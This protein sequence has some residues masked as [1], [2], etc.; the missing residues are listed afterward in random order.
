MNSFLVKDAKYETLMSLFRGDAFMKKAV[1]ILSFLSVSAC[2]NS[3]IANA[4]AEDLSAGGVSL[5]VARGE[6]VVKEYQ[7]PNGVVETCRI[8]EKLPGGDYSKKDMVQEEKLCSFDFYDSGKIALCAK[9][10][11]T[12]PATMVLK[13]NKSLNPKTNNSFTAQEYEASSYCGQKT[14]GP[15]VKT[16]AK[17]KTTMNQSD[18][19]GT[20]SQSSLLYYHFSRLLDTKINVPVSVY[21]E[22]DRQVMGERVAQRSGRKAKRGRIASGWKWMRKTADNPSS[23]KPTH[24]LITEDRDK[25]YGI[26]IRG[27]GARYGTI[28]NGTRPSWG[29]GDAKAFKNTPAFY[30]LRSAKPLREAIKE[31][32]AKAK[33]TRG[34]SQHVD[35]NISNLQMLFWMREL[36]ELTLLDYIFSQQDRVGNIDFDWYWYYVKDGEVKRTKESRDEYKKLSRA[37]M[38]QIPVPAE[39]SSYQ[40]TLVQRTN[41]NDNDAGGLVRY[42]NWA[43][44]S[45]ADWLSGQKHY[46]KK[47]F[48]N[49]MALNEDLQSGGPIKLWLETQLNLGASEVRQVVRNTQLAVQNILPRCE[50]LM[51]DLDDVDSFLT[52][53][54]RSEAVDC[55][56][57]R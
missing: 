34:M 1:I 42:A 54:F 44:E 37:K 22:M 5:E 38:G 39:L 36:T 15:G 35:K 43:K 9:T 21:R 29:N 11:S 50:Q 30:A 49:L 52:E 41:L 51:F 48:E 19:S 18:T 17:F 32:I 27:K 28:V 26:L 46:S 24:H 10:W 20:F 7:S 14:K 53:G 2:S 47:L 45:K 33:K 4:A 12:S 23:Y 3:T 40:P 56:Q 6:E 8:I 55:N 57:Y 25:F 31:G 13:L 16:G